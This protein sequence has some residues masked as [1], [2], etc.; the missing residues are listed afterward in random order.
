MQRDHEIA[1]YGECLA[2]CFDR[3]FFLGD[4]NYRHIL[5]MYFFSY[6]VRRLEAEKQWVQT[7]LT[8][9][10]RMLVLND[11]LACT[12]VSMLRKSGELTEKRCVNME[13][14]CENEARCD[15]RESEVQMVHVEIILNNVP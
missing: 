1:D 7:L 9:R 15:P 12:S 2:K 14:V 10:E 4:L 6:H 5:R 11:E 8:M 13:E 3:C